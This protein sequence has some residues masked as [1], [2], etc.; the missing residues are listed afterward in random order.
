MKLHFVTDG[1]SNEQTNLLRSIESVLTGRSSTAVFELKALDVFT[2]RGPEK[3]KAFV[4]D[5][6]GA[7]QMEDLEV[8]LERTGL[9]LITFYNAVKGVPVA[10]TARR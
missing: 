8:L 10:L 7:F 3:S 9:D 6:L 5:R 4:S 1:L 2:N